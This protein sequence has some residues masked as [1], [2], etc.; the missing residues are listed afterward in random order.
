M[1]VDHLSISIAACLREVLQAIDENQH[2]VIFFTN[3]Y[4]SVVGVATDGDIR[5]HLLQ[6]GT[7]DDQASLC[8]NYE[9]VWERV[10]TPRETLLKK[11]DH[12]IRL[13]PLLDDDM[14]LVDLVS[15]DHLPVQAEGSVYARARAPVRISFGGG[16]S[17]L[18]HY[19]S[20]A[21][22]A[23][24]N[25]TVSLYGHATLRMRTDEKIF[26]HSMD[27]D[28]ELRADN[29]SDALK[30]HSRFKL[31]QALLKA[32]RPDF[33]FDLFLYSDF[34][35]KSGLGGSSVI[36][37]A[38]LGCFNQF[39]R[40]KWDLYDLAEISYQAER[41][42]LDIAGGWQDQYAAVFGGFNFMEFRMDQNIVHPLR[43]PADTLLEL[44]ESL[45]LCDTETIHESGDIH[46]DQREHM[47]VAN[48]SSMVRENVDLS[49][50]MRDYLLRGKLAHF[51]K[52]M[53]QAWHLKR[54]LSNKISSP[55]LDQI[56]SEAKANGATAGKLLGAGGGGFFVF[57]APM[58]QRH[59]LISHLQDS[60]FGVRPF[61]FE[62]SGLQAWTVREN[63]NHYKRSRNDV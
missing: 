51:A 1:Q 49:Y 23:V 41:H 32:I 2:G 39:R 28:D 17:D 16:G 53:D 27:L 50:K 54:Q 10:D 59:R 24:I 37:A 30:P 13:I 61:R 47:A 46:V 60:G 26:I 8:A 20:G 6:G 52:A 4:G 3:E 14:R 21:K 18:T 43:I 45:V 48:T 62:S 57:Y 5:R 29:L 36:S 7:L 42:H 9:F 22:S 19:F 56:Y 11:L 25:A 44:E 15:R 63:M 38:V 33:G 31:I 12:Q 58:Y 34:P 35:M 40:D 55:Y